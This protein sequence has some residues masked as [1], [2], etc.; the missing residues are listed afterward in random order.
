VLSLFSSCQCLFSVLSSGCR[1]AHLLVP[2]L[3]ASRILAP[4]LLSAARG[5]LEA[6]KHG[7]CL[8]LTAETPYSRNT[9]QRPLIT[10]WRTS[11]GSW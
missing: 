4:S 7:Q 1:L 3:V 2:S 6:G 9:I 5:D 11:L 8:P 10:N